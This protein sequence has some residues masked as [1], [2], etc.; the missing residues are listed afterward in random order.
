MNVFQF[1][2]PASGSTESGSGGDIE[3]SALPEQE[4]QYDLRT[5]GKTEAFQINF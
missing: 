2:E 5:L 4:P 3:D 1:F